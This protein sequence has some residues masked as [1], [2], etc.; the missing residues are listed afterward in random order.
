MAPFPKAGGQSD[1]ET[2]PCSEPEAGPRCWNGCSLFQTE[3]CDLV[4]RQCGL[5]HFLLQE[6]ALSSSWE[7]S[8]FTPTAGL[9]LLCLP[10]APT[11]ANSYPMPSNLHGDLAILYACGCHQSRAKGS[12]CVQRSQGHAGQ[13]GPDRLCSS[14]MNAYRPADPGM[15]GPMRRPGPGLPPCRSGEKWPAGHL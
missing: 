6:A 14:Q 11:L 2:L 9:Y 5:G 8:L 13:E 7:P 4:D 3:P 12:P 10:R 15:P 1:V